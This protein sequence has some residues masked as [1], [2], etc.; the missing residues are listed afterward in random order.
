MVRAVCEGTMSDTRD[1]YRDILLSVEEGLAVLTLNR[2]QA[3]N[4]LSVNLCDEV[5]AALAALRADRTVRVLILTGAGDRA[6]CA[7][8]DLKERRGMADDQLRAHNRKIARVPSELERLEIPTIAALNGHALG[9]GCEV[10]MGCDL[11][12]AADTALL[13]Q[14]EVALGIIP[15]GGATQRLPR[16]VGPA[17]AKELIFTGRRIT[18]AEA[19]R[20]GLLNAVAPAAEVLARARALA[21]EI[22]RNAPLAVRGAK[23][24]IALGLESGLEAGLALEAHIQFGLYRSKDWAEGLAAFNEK[25]APHWRGE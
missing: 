2:P 21:T 25:R 23:Q 24:A 4:A 16:L 15:A 7:G 20:I 14:T 10:A 17:R 13:G 19:E 12:I 3:L 18:A 9:G 5:L 8:A 1:A 22:A 11:R 6:F